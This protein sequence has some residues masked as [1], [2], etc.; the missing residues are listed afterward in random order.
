M[1]DKDGWFNMGQ[2]YD[3]R[4]HPNWLQKRPTGPVSWDIKLQWEVIGENIPANELREF[5]ISRG[6]LIPA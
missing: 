6:L 4:E 5:L 1:K 2:S 3:L